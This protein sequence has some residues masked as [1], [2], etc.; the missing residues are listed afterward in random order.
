VIAKQG[1]IF[2]TTRGGDP[3]VKPAARRDETPRGYAALPG[4]GPAGESCKTCRFAYS[5][6]ATRRYWK[7]GHAA[8]PR[9]THGYGTDIRLKSP[10][11]RFWLAHP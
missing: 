11:C 1:D 8:A 4:T 3:I 7:C 9:A 5:R 2:G 10:A 6:L